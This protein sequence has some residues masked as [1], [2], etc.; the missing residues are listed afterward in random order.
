MK[1]FRSSRD[2]SLAQ[3]ALYSRKYFDAAVMV[4]LTGM[5]VMTTLFLNV[6]SSLPPTDYIRMI[7]AWLIFGMIMPFF[8]VLIH[9][10]AEFK[11]NQLDTETR[12]TQARRLKVFMQWGIWGICY[13]KP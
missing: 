13:K 10:I 12:A 2:H 7:D 3:V 1:K 6:S 9:A 5:L 11:A 4:S 8:D